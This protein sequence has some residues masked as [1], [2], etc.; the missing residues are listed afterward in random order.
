M[1]Y[2]GST[3]ASSVANPP[4][5][6]VQTF[7]SRG[8]YDSTALSGAAADVS[9]NN[10]GGSIWSYVSTDAVGT[11]ITTGYFS[12]GHKLGMHPG[13]HVLGV[14]TSTNGGTVTSYFGTVT[15]V[16]TNGATVSAGTVA[17]T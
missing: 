10:Q 14:V 12:D 7:T 5:C 1:A 4:R 11:V 8:A 3:A 6:I 15:S 2:N 13:D 16:S 17:T 9:L